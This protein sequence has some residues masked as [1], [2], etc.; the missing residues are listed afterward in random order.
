MTTH[1]TSSLSPLGQPDFWQAGS[2]CLAVESLL[3]NTDLLLW[4][5]CAMCHFYRCLSF[6]SQVYLFSNTA[7]LCSGPLRMLTLTPNFSFSCKRYNFMKQKVVFFIA[8]KAI[9]SVTV[10]TAGYFRAFLVVAL[11][12]LKVKNFVSVAQQSGR[13]ISY[14]IFAQSDFWITFWLHLR[15]AEILKILM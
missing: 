1:S 2:I 8:G 12:F 5:C 4:A 11:I 13:T 3:E 15:S 14:Q 10:I 9:S 6:F 7:G